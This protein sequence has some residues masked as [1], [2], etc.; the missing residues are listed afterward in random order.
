MAEKTVI[1]CALTGSADTTE[2]NPAVPITPEQIA[3]SALD[4]EKAGA[5]AVHIHVR[6]PQT[7]MPSMDPELYRETVARIRDAGSNLV[8]NLTTGPGGSLM[9]GDADPVEST[10]KSGLATPETRM[11]HVKDNLPDICTLDVSTMNFGERAMINVP[12]HLR[13]MADMARALGVKPEL[14]VFDTGHVLLAKQLIKEGHLEEDALFQLCLGIPWGCPATPEGMAYMKSLLPPKARWS[15]FGISR[16]EF[17]MVA[18]AVT[19]GGHT[20]VGL[21]DNLYL[22]RGV[23]ANSNAQLVERA[24]DIVESIGGSVA[25]PDETRIAFGLGRNAPA[26]EATA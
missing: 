14:E 22:A 9:P 15:A 12:K 26:S 11:R 8:I 3:Q 23:L 25:T 6:D 10:G 2:K 4:C 16:W 13:A 20:R 18:Q 17:P 7:G 21:E 5:G 19:L 1:T 24:V